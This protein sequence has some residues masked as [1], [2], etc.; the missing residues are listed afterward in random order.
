[1]LTLDTK[2]LSKA[3]GLSAL[4]PVSRLNGLYNM[5]ALIKNQ[6][7]RQLDIVDH[8][9]MAD[10][11]MG[12]SA[13]SSSDSDTNAQ[14]Q[15]SAADPSKSN[16]HVHTQTP[17]R[18]WDPELAKDEVAVLLSGGVD[19]SVALKLL[20]DQGHKVRAFYLKIWLEDEVAH[21]NECPWEEDLGYAQ[22]W[23]MT[24]TPSIPLFSG[25]I[26]GTNEKRSRQK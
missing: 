14:G 11:S 6:V 12:T 23:S 24:F 15:T 21:L 7:K 2:E 19:S 10:R 26:G 18:P 16:A 5:V 3:V 25:L 20:L 13:T 9:G 1:V 22:V 4:L 8:H 17:A